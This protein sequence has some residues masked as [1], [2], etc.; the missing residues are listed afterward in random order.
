LTACFTNVSSETLKPVSSVELLGDVKAPEDVSAIAKLGALLVIGADEAVGENEDQNIIQ[1]MEQVGAN[2]YKVSKDILLFEGDKEDG[3]EMDI[4]GIAVSGNLVYVIGSHSAKR[5]RIKESEKYETNREA[6]H[7]E[8]ISPEKNRGWL[9]RLEFNDD[10]D[11]QDKDHISLR[12][13]IEDDEVL[14][15]FSKL[16]SKENG[17]DIEGI[18]AMGDSLY[19]GFRGPVLRGNWVPVMKLEFDDQKEYELL[20]V[21]LGGR[22]IR[23]I[24]SVGDGFLL[25]A[26]PVGDGP[27]SYQLY[28]WDGKDMIPGEDRDPKD[29]GKLILLGEIEPPMSVDP[30]ARAKAE[31]IVSLKQQ[32]TEYDL[33]VVYD[34]GANGAAQRFRVPKP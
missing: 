27:T 28:H 12:D 16:P 26:G 8:E 25:I 1:L 20:Y 4:E 17:V 11:V 30:P 18:G 9:Y 7:E 29:V 23:D 5:T 3:K 34:S 15:T 13:I 32:G 22:G 19:L 6:L 14:K 10:G 24:T 33:I 2:S 31:G 21:D